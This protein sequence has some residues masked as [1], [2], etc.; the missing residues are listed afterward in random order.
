MQKPLK[1]PKLP[2]PAK[3]PK[4]RVYLAKY[5]EKEKLWRTAHPDNIKQYYTKQNQKR[6]ERNK[7]NQIQK[8][9]LQI[10]L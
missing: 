1:V 6:S 2:K 8:I 7:W 3:P 5:V 9:Y 10:L 4:P